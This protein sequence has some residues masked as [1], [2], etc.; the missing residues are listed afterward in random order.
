MVFEP[1][2]NAMYNTCQDRPTS[3]LEFKVTFSSDVDLGQSGSQLLN[4]GCF[5]RVTGLA[6]R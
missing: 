5:D 2:A 6:I 3:L 1:M 4:G